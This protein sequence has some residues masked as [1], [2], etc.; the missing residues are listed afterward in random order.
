MKSKKPR[1]T[2]VEQLRVDV[3]RVVDAYGRGAVPQL[4]RVSGITSGTIRRFLEEPE[5]SVTKKTLRGLAR[6]LNDWNPKQFT[7]KLTFSEFLDTEYGVQAEIMREL[8]CGR[9]TLIRA[10]EGKPIPSELKAALLHRYP[11]RIFPGSI[12]VTQY[13]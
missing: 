1:R 11:G 2:L 6:V 13:R 12:I 3:Q 7:S 4:V 9:Q 10:R 5:V 8:R